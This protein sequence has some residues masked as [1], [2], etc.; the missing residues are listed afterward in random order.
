MQDTIRLPPPVM[1]LVIEVKAK[2]DLEKLRSALLTLTREDCLLCV[3]F[4]QPSGQFTLKG[5][6]ERHLDTKIT[7]LR[8]TCGLDVF[9]GAPEVAY[10]ETITRLVEQDYTYERQVGGDVEFARLRMVFE[11]NKSDQHG[12]F[13]S[14]ITSDTFPKECVSGVEKGVESVMQAGILAGFP[15]VNVTA[16]LIDGA[17][18]DGAS[19]ARAFEI[20][21]RTASRKALE[22]GGPLLLEPVMK[23]E[24]STPR[25]YIGAVVGDLQSRRGRVQVEE[26]SANGRVVK[27]MVPLANMFG[28]RN[29]LRSFFPRSRD[30]HDGVRAVRAHPADA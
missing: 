21:A 27:A 2:A 24:V 1:K 19:S 25:K 13:A 9:I 7:S 22:K 4:D 3:S 20:A 26:N 16:T 18:R 14:K 30:V 12:V 6:D 17:F 8:R 10:L 29:Q 23:V 11:P 15:V 28:Y 5:T